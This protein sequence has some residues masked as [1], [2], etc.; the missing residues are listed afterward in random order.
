MD[1]ATLQSRIIGQLDNR[2]D[3]SGVVYD[4]CLDR[5]G[6]WREFFFYS[7]NVTDTSIITS[8]GQ[9]FYDLPNSMRNV[10]QIRLL[11]PGNNAAYAVTR[12]SVTL[13]NATV[14]AS[15]TTGFTTTGSI[16]VG[17]QVVSY[18]GITTNSFTGCAGG[19]GVIIQG[20]GITQIAPTTNTTVDVTLPATTIAVASTSGFLPAGMITLGG[21]QVAYQ[22]IDGTHFLGCVGGTAGT[23]SSGAQVNQLYGIWVPLEKIKYRDL[24]VNDPLAPPNQAQPSMWAPF[25]TQFRLYPNPDQNYSLELTGN[26]GPA[27]P[28]ND[29]DTNFWTTDAAT[30]IIHSTTAE[31][32]EMYLGNEAAAAKYRRGEA[33]ERYKLQKLSINL[34]DPPVVRGWL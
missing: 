9:Y 8:A 15:T 6:F 33:R 14:P 16:R 29:Q 25:N 13:P 1:F 20:T 19:A 32:Y 23:I 4:Y 2:A 12:L 34:G 7:S 22:S 31:V 27:A 24:L 28:V 5:I 18:T 17:S 10:Q 26:T 30:L 21:T 11:I 3:L